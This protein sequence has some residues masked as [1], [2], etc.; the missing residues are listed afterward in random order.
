MSSS[1][2][3]AQQEAKSI[4]PPVICLDSSSTGISEDD[5]ESIVSACAT[6]QRSHKTG[7]PHGR[8]ELPRSAEAIYG[9]MLRSEA[10]LEGSSGS[11]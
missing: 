6:P 2:A 11:R 10:L 3:A 8:S 5:R 9:C 4:R 1:A 7:E